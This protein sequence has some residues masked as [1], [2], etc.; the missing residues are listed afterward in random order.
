MYKIN[1]TLGSRW[2]KR[3]RETPD[4]FHDDETQVKKK[5]KE[6]KTCPSFIIVRSWTAG[7]YLLFASF[8]F[9]FNFNF[10]LSSVSIDKYIFH[11][12]RAR[13]ICSTSATGHKGT[14]ALWSRPPSLSSLS[15]PTAFQTIFIHN[16]TSDPQHTELFM[17]FF[18][19][20]HLPRISLLYT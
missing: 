4:S 13:D 14:S 20:F 15:S 5:K 19:D 8:F 12:W 16:C 2:K 3:R 17:D 9:F 1:K 11:N 18:S 6:K 10:N 7:G